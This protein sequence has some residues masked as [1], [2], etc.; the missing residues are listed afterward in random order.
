MATT[1]YLPEGVYLI[2]PEHIVSAA[3]LRSDIPCRTFNINLR[4][5]KNTG[6]VIEYY[7]SL[8]WADKLR[9]ISYDQVKDIFQYHKPL[10]YEATNPDRNEVLFIN[11]C[12]RKYTQTRALLP[13]W[14]TN[15]DIENINKLNDIAKRLNHRTKYH[16][17]I[18][19]NLPEP[20]VKVEGIEIHT[21][22]IKYLKLPK[23]EY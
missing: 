23:R 18:S 1:T 16:N 2:L 22:E 17:A 3:T 21:V 12:I 4:I 14:M 7:I 15:E 13:D 19:A 8:G 20:Y 5:D 9:R 10:P 6:N 11:N